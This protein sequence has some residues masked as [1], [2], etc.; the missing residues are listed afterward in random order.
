MGGVGSH[1]SIGDCLRKNLNFFFPEKN[2]SV[3]SVVIEKIEYAF[4]RRKSN[5]VLN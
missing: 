3:E 5:S 4:W 2:G 1:Q